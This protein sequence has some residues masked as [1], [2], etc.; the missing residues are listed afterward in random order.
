MCTWV[1]AVAF[2]PVEATVI[3][4]VSFD[5]PGGTFALFHGP[6]GASPLICGGQE[7]S[8]ALAGSGIIDVVV[9]LDPRI[10]TVVGASTTSQLVG[11]AGPFASL[12]QERRAK[13]GPGSIRWRGARCPNHDRDGVSQA[14]L[15][16]G[17]GIVPTDKTDAP[18]LFLHELGH[19][20]AFNGFPNST[21]GETNGSLHFD[22]RSACA[23]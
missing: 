14:W 11:T 20:Y 7:W 10:P 16:F 3:D 6:V 15:F 1:L 9:G 19:I 5:D 4:T 2:A 12:N 21:T 8:E 23:L 17:P 13:S 18:S 22:L